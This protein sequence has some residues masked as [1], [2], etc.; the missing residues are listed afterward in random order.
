MVLKMEV[1]V[2]ALLGLGGVGSLGLGAGQQSGFAQSASMLPQ[3]TE[4]P[5]LGGKQLIVG[6]LKQQLLAW[7]DRKDC[8]GGALKLLCHIHFPQGVPYL[9]GSCSSCPWT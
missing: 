3:G 4:Q 1:E 5:D 2:G 6:E 9:P 8:V 7:Q